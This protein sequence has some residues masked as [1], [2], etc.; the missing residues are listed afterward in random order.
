MCVR[1]QWAV[2]DQH[3][4]SNWALQASGAGHRDTVALLHRSTQPQSAS[5]EWQNE[6]RRAC[7]L[8]TITPS[9]GL[10]LT[11]GQEVACGQQR[12]VTVNFLLHQTYMRIHKPNYL[13]PLT[14]SI[15]TLFKWSDA[16]HKYTHPNV[17][18]MHYSFMFLIYIFTV[19]LYIL[20]LCCWGGI[21]A[22]IVFV[23]FR[24]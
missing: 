1:Q 8:P 21:V 14:K 19:I 11:M 2:K 9:L 17:W 12:W 6:G 15:P 23:F 4:N 7:Q 13:T 18:A 3:I 16:L 24:D 20:F 10:A 22:N 5:A